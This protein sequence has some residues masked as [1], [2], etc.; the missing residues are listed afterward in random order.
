[1]KKIE[2]K[3]ELMHRE[4]KERRLQFEAVA[5]RLRLH[6]Q[7]EGKRFY[8]LTA[9]LRNTSGRTIRNPSFAIALIIPSVRSIPLY[10]PETVEID[11]W[12]HNGILSFVTDAVELPP[13]EFARCMLCDI[14]FRG[15]IR[16]PWGA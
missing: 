10:A 3:I 11:E 6:S 1:M 5:L 15:E 8:E 2:K 9:K 14:T 16:Q 12:P 7:E 13:D 4:K